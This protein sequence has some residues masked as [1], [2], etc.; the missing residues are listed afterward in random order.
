MNTSVD[1]RESVPTD[2]YKSF[3]NLSMIAVGEH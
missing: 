3:F 1:T 2:I